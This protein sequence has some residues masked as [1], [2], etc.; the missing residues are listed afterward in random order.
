L[1][2]E[3]FANVF[4][5][6]YRCHPGFCYANDCSSTGLKREVDISLNMINKKLRESGTKANEG[7]EEENQI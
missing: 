3:K 2:G 6:R 4:S 5:G 1:W 7:Y